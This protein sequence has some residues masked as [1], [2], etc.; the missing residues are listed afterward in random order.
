MSKAI[1]SMT[2]EF[3][4]KITMECVSSTMPGTQIIDGSNDKELFIHIQR[5]DEQV[6][7]I[8]SRWRL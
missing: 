6:I 1:I 4:K 2:D 7:M 3:T 8:F 5:E